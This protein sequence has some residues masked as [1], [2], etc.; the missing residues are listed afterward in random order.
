MQW[1]L[2]M[3]AGLTLAWAP[4]ATAKGAREGVDARVDQ[5]KVIQLPPPATEGRVSLEHVLNARRSVREFSTEPLSA[6][7]LSQLLWSAQGVTGRGGLRTAPSAGALYPLGLYVATA[8]GFFHYEPRGHR[9]LRLFSRDPRPA[10]RRAA[11]DQAPVGA[12]P[13]VFVIAARIARTEA[14]YGKA[15]SPRYVHME[16]GHAAQNLL[17]QAVALGRAGVPIGAFDDSRVH[18]ALAL[19]QGEVPLYLIAVGMPR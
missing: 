17:L 2:F 11:L 13:A 5:S 14:K 6:V 7:E 9:M 3:M 8:D 1:I 4:A 10:L 18:R 12:A 16:A 15:R 19:P